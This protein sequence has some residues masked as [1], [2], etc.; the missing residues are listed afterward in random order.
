MAQITWRNV[1]AP[2]FSGSLDGI[3]TAAYL[4]GNA[5]NTLSQGLGDFRQAQQDQ[6][7]SAV[8]QN[9]LK[10]TD[11]AQYQAAL[12]DGSLFNGIDTSQLNARTLNGLSSRTG[13]LINNA[14]NQESLDYKNYTFGREKTQNAALDAAAPIMAQISNILS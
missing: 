6:A 2:N 9:A 12:A 4:F 13:D 10:F 11:P 1:D 8:T 5:G 7:A 3:K 14:L